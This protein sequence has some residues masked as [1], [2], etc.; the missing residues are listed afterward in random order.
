MNPAAA[1]VAAGGAWHRF[2]P[3]FFWGIGAL[4]YIVAVTNRTS[5]GVAGIDAVHRF[6]IGPTVLSLF[7]VLQLLVYAIAQVPVGLALDHFGARRMIASG[8]LLMALGQLLLALSE[9]AL[10]AILGRAIVGLGDAMTFISVL[11][12]TTAWFSANRVPLMTQITGLLGWFGQVLS[13]IPFA[14]ILHLYGW[15]TAFNVLAIISF[16]AAAMTMSF[17]RESPGSP[18][19][20]SWPTRESLS[21]SLQITWRDPAMHLGFWSHWTTPFSSSVF[22]LIWGVPFLVKAE[23]YTKSAASNFLTL[24]VLF[25]ALSGLILGHLTTRYAEHLANMTY[26]ITGFQAL[27][28]L[29]TLL[30]PGRIPTGDIVVLL[31]MISAGGPGSL[32]GFAHARRW[33]PIERIGTADGFINGAGFI[34]GLLAMFGVG[35]VLQWQGDYSLHAFKLAFAVQFPIWAIGIAQIVRLNRKIGGVIGKALDRR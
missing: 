33:I 34:S 7:T 30:W 9:Q 32:I 22:T 14:A 6:H 31:I 27:A 15:H 13:A 25:G 23:G 24:I 19:H 29:V 16:A 28:W 17:L 3:V 4:A 20:L 5:F 8:A 12:I 11:R 2:A 26:V 21:A 18:S 10:P 35:L 1:S